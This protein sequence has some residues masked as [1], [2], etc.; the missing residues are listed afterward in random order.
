MKY[1]IVGGVAGGATAAA[2]IRRLDENAVIVLFERGEHISFA[3]CGLPYFIGGTIKERSRLFVTTAEAF[4]ARYRVDVRPG[5]EVIS[6]DRKAKK[7]RVR[8]ISGGR[9]YDESYDKLLLSPG[10]EPVK[11]PIPGIDTEGIFTLRNIPDTD[12]I[13][14][15]LEMKRPESA[16]V[17]G[18]GFIGLEMAENLHHLGIRVTIVEALDQV[19]TPIDFEMAAEVHRHIRSKN[20]DLILSDGVKSF[21]RADGGVTVTLASGRTISA[22]I[23]ILSI[24]VRPESSLARSSGLDITERGAIVVD[25][26]LKTGDENIYAVGDAVAVMHKVSGTRMS[27]YLAG[28]ANKQARIVADNMVRGDTRIYRG[29]AATAIAKVFDLAVASTGL[30]EKAL[31]AAG[32]E[33]K[34][35][36][37][38]AS[39][40][41]GYY[42]DAKPLSVKL[43]FSPEGRILGGQIV[44]YDGVDARID[45]IA[46]V[47][48]MNGT[49][50]DL[51]ELDHAYA[52]PYSSAKDPVNAAAFAAENIVD[53]LVRTV[54][55]N[56]INK[57]GDTFLLDV[58][59]R[60]EFSLGSIPGSVN[61]PVDELRENLAMIPPNRTIIVNCAAGLRGYL[62][63]RIL[64]QKGF[65]DVYNLSGG[66]KTYE[67]AS[68]G[69]SGHGE[70]F[71]GPDDM[72]YRKGVAPAG[73]QTHAAMILDA[74]GLQCPGPIIKLKEAMDGSVEGSELVVVASDPGFIRDVRSW[75]TLTGNILV[76]VTED[77]GKITAVVRKG[78]RSAE[79]AVVSTG[80]G[81][82]IIVFS[83]DL[84]KALAAFVLA[85]G[86]AAAGKKVTMFFTFWGLSVI[87]K[88]RAKGA[89][90]DF[91]GKMFSLMLPKN[92]RKL[93]LSKINMGGM[94]SMLMRFRMRRKKVESLEKMIDSAAAAGVEMIGCQ[95]SM[96]IM[97]VSREE[98][99]EFVKI[100]GVA[101]YLEA[102]SSSG[103]NLFV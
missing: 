100:G 29:S 58:R 16:V 30:S 101:T 79:N 2:R 41:A 11:P 53:G 52:P 25:D 40:H 4:R 85:N 35:V 83:D 22:G 50:R 54:N 92:S 18:G 3:N 56:E 21:A 27:I 70:E 44:G 43:V 48:G 55:W 57:H 15:H 7:I 9:E 69:D 60:N 84:D 102:A 62:A 5:N 46:A 12:A 64:M 66:Y 37:T 32:I 86:G 82:T 8:E 89:K 45:M 75:C 1:C 90:K 99:F 13:R 49:V 87:K 93:S 42:P 59:S 68:A 91:L 14:N 103:I 96:D 97:G 51:A 24:G 33:C 63:S 6:I 26:H 88:P 65:K 61:I 36:V 47:I 17:V 73:L 71:V 10:A 81:E 72:T 20:V 95:M 77:A 80:A 34:S 74:C 28:P 67:S 76:S 78:A 94:G 31:R 98:L 19:M 38:H 23:V 39:S